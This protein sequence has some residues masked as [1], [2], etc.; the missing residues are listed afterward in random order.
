MVFLKLLSIAHFNIFNRKAIGT[1]L[2]NINLFFFTA[3]SAVM[4]GLSRVIAHCPF[5]YFH[6][7]G[8]KITKFIP[9]R[10]EA[11]VQKMRLDPAHILFKTKVASQNV[12]TEVMNGLSEVIVHCTFKYFPWKG[13]R[14][15][16]IQYKG[17]FLYY[18]YR[19]YERSFLGY[20]LLPTSIFSTAKCL[21]NL[22]QYK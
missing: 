2:L 19:S 3:P 16:S 20:C 17:I 5:Q 7:Q 18:S 12:T 6:G 14:H 1:I 9:A 21:K 10:T 4:N 22:F 13:T 11:K 15:Y 8:V